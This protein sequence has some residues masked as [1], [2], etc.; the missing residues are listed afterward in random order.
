MLT[1]YRATESFACPGED[2]Y[3]RMVQIGSLFESGD[4]VMKGRGQ[5]FE[6]VETTA[7]RQAGVEVEEAKADAKVEEATAE[8]NMKRSVSTTKPMHG[9]THS[10]VKRSSQAKTKE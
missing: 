6:T 9:E 7:A 1:V 8:P 2:G 5:Y 10:T 3:T 4:P